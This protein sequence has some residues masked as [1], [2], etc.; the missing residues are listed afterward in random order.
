MGV[1]ILSLTCLVDA[2]GTGDNLQCRRGGG[3]TDW[4]RSSL[5]F[6]PYCK[7]NITVDRSIAKE[8]PIMI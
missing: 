6:S 2:G 4:R 1:K 7:I 3:A 8:I 5:E